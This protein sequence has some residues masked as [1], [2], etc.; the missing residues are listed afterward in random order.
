MLA[1]IRIKDLALID[2][3]TLTFSDG[4]NA[5]TG[6]T[7]TGK[8]MVVESIFLLLGAKADV[9]RVRRGRDAAEVEGLFLDGD[10]ET[11]L[12][13]RVG[14]DGRSRAY[15]DG[16]LVT[17]KELSE[18]GR[19]LIETCGQGGHQAL[20]SPAVRLSLIDRFGAGPVA[21]ALSEYRGFREEWTTATTV[22]KALEAAAGE[23][24]ERRH[25]L[26]WRI[27]ELERTELQPGEELELEERIARLAN[28][29]E[30]REAAGEALRHLDDRAID[31]T[32]DAI[33]RLERAAA[34]DE[35]VEA[36]LGYVRSAAAELDEAVFAVRRYIEGL[37]DDS[38]SL[39]AL[40]ER[41]FLIK[42]LAR[43]YELSSD[44]LIG[45]LDTDRRE[46][47]ALYDNGERLEEARRAAGIAEERLAEAAEILGGRR[48]EAGDAFAQAVGGQLADLAFN[49]AIFSAAVT[50]DPEAGWNENG[51]NRV[52]FLFSANQ[53]EEP[54]PL[55]RVVSGGESSRVMLAVKSVFG[56]RDTVQ[57][58]LFDE[59]DA[60]VGGRTAVRV[61]EKLAAL[62]NSRQV[63]AVTHL[64]PVA[65][66]ADHHL[67]VTK[68]TRDGKTTICVTLVLGDDRLSELS[69]LGGTLDESL[70]SVEHAKRLVDQAEAKKQ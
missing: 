65:A 38:D 50:S 47:A 8:S 41:L 16:R 46:L 35:G 63:L 27:E 4:L 20:G 5:I 32:H 28:L 1:E 22:L 62:A 2:E 55:A 68:S 9:S 54:R 24:G 66:F 51:C 36:A 13:R 15:I 60:G 11:V 39:A 3:M 23:S 25:F 21:A 57:T 69:R 17:L 7:G 10:E 29:A 18:I 44:E 56:Q 37:A 14:K 19:T 49:Q 48:R 58:L 30:L 33:G 31:G 52:E 61:G 53:G 64:A 45:R 59:I 70:V 12:R 43:K 42:D 40:Q 6:E 26:E 67:A 34:K